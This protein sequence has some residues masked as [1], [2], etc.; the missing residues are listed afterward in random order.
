MFYKVIYH[1]FEGSRVVRM[2][3]PPPPPP[4]NTVDVLRDSG[5]RSA[6]AHGKLVVALL[7]TAKDRSRE[8]NTLVW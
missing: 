6:C 2:P 4:P 5:R 1:Y 7:E 3:P 8:R